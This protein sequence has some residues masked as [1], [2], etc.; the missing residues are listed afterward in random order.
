MKKVKLYIAALACTM[1]G[2]QG[3]S[4]ETEVYDKIDASQYPT[5]E[6]DA[7]DLVTA[8]AYSVFRNGEYEGIFNIAKGYPILAEMATDI[9]YTGWGDQ[10][11]AVQFGNYHYAGG[12]KNPRNLWGDY[13]HW[14]GRME[15]TLD[16]IKSIDMDE[17]K[18]AR[19]LAEVEVAQGFLGF[20]LWDF[21]GPLIIADLEALKNH[22]DE[23]LILPR[24]TEEETIAYIERKLKAGIG[25]LDDYIP[26][27]SADYGRFTGAL[28]HT[29]LMKLYMQSRQWGKAIAEGRELM[30]PKYGFALVKDKGKAA[31]CYA[32]IFTYENEGNKET[33]WAINHDKE[34]HF[35]LW[36][37][38]VVSWSGFCMPWIF[39]DSF[40]EGDKRIANDNVL[41]VYDS[42]QNIYLPRKYTMKI[43][44]NTDGNKS[45]TDWIVYRY[46]DVLT[47][48]SEAIVHEGGAVTKEALDLL[49]EVHTRD[50]LAAYQMTDFA[51]AQAF[52]DELLVDRSHEF[53]Y[54]GCRRQDLIRNDKYVET[55][56][57]KCEAWPFFRSP[58]AIRGIGEKNSHRFP[59]PSNFCSEGL[60]GGYEYQNPGYGI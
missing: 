39:I 23:F 52:I 34:Y 12:E 40:K 45:W 30:N 5:T 57:K 21:Y 51:D 47:M 28:C 15:L 42:G 16:R 55:I 59:L 13:I 7:K 17:T 1:L 4:L 33:I 46:A 53:W 2:M 60:K 10:W 25:V 20:I 11:E 58:D 3:C 26:H 22:R 56:A 24:S 6:Q 36:Y 38:H 48:L 43:G 8:N 50:G 35:N 9:A 49:N 41:A 32:N 18:K 44:E 27:N 31:S 29:V 19:Y 37:A 54:E 14:L